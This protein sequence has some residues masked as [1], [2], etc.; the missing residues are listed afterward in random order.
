MHRKSLLS[1]AL[2]AAVMFHIA[3]MPAAQAA[4]VPP[5]EQTTSGQPDS[6]DEN[7][8]WLGLIGLAGL[9]GLRGRS[10]REAEGRREQTYPEKL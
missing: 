1:A 2:A 6:R 4:P 3:D 7:L 9:L 5:H 8:G 10:A